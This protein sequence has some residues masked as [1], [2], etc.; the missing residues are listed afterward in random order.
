MPQEKKIWMDGRLVNDNEA[1]VHVLSHSLHYG[2]AAFEGIRAYENASGRAAVF[3]LDEHIKRL[4]DSCRA[5]TIDV[6]YTPKELRDATLEVLRA[7]QLKGCYIRPIVFLGEGSVAVAAMD[8][9]V[10]VAIAAWT[11]GAYLGEEALEKGVRC[12]ISSFTRIDVRSH[13]EK[14]KICGQYVNSV[15]AKREANRMGFDEAIMLD[16]QGS[17]SE[18]TGENVF[19]VRSGALITPD[20][21][22]SILGG[23]TRDTVITLAQHMGLPVREARITRT[24]LYLA[25]EVFFTGTAAEVTPVREIDGRLIGEGK[26]GPV[27]AKL[28][29]AYFASVRGEH[30]LAG[31]WRTEF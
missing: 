28:Q 31:P 19:V 24:E 8:N 22:S 29:D 10:R 11:W 4:F 25:D 12:C 20:S 7:N 5:A 30:I 16:S 1:Q 18:G 14:A 9:K 17:V 13:L 3:R 6:P 2:L 26:R 27:T 23:I 15:L 21:G